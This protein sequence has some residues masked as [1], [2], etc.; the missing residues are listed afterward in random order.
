MKLT[1][2][3]SL[4]E[5]KLNKLF[6]IK[7]AFGSKG[8]KTVIVDYILPRLED[9][10]NSVL[11]KLSD[12]RIRFDTQRDS[13][14]GENQVERL[15]ITIINEEGEE[16]AFENYSGGERLKI[17]VAISEAL[18]Y[19]QP[20]GFRIFDEVF[21]GLDDASTE[22]FASVLD[23]IQNHYDMKNHF[24][25]LICVS[26]MG[27]I[28]DMFDKVIAVRKNGGISSILQKA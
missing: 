16:M 23:K 15:F 17:T 27:A 20:V 10:V 13:L 2:D 11:S 4:I 21:I 25:Q 6:M 8:I 22:S 26:H 18:A 9:G 3:V 12:L 28:K 5:G 1:S 14:D 7:E 19:L 24:S